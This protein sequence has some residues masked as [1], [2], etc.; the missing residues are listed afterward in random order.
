MFHAK[1]K[2]IKFETKVS[3]LGILEV[4]FE[5]TVI[6]LGNSTPKFVKKR[7]QNYLI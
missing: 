6:I 3:Y 7:H 4:E 5:K 1:R 2:R